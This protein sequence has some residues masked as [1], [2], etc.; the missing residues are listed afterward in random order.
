MRFREEKDTMGTVRV[1]ENAY[2]G[3]QT[4]R[5]VENFPISGLRFPVEFIH[6][7]ALIKKCSAS[8]NFELGQ[9]DVEISRAIISAAREVM[10]GKF[11]DQFVVDLF[12]TGSGTSTNMNMNEVITSRAN[13][14]I[15]GK[16]NGKSPVHPNDHVNLG[17]SSNDVIPS[18]I[19]IAALRA[20]HVHLIPS[21][22][23][24]HTAILQKS[25]EFDEIRKIGRTHLQDAVPMT[26]GQEFSGFARQMELGVQRIKGVESRLAELALGGTAVGTGLNTHPEFGARVI[27]LVAEHTGLPFT[28]AINFFEAQAARDAAVEASGV[29]KTIAVSLVKIANDI[30]WLA[31]GPRCGLGE[32]KIPPLQPGSSIMPGKVNPV[33]PEAVIQVAAQVVGNDT[34]ITIGGQGGSFE[35]N[36]MLPVISY[37]LLQSIDLLAAVSVV[38][39]RKCIAGISANAEQCEAYIE[40]SLALATCLVPHIGYDRASEIAKKAYQTGKTIRETAAMEEDLPERMLARIF[41]DQ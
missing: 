41:N 40:Q 29:L 27:R 11:D 13:E 8:V 22:Q 7:L 9:L 34:A 31:S 1:P 26:L 10:N 32:I 15:T 16:K 35:L 2:F 28:L 24:M 3:P 33:I 23:L 18:T 37:N 39:A 14:I 5:A 12:Q 20:I 38:F 25:A 19:H 4:Q 21:L 17:Q 36:A 30:R 6:A